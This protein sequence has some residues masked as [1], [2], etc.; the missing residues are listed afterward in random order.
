MKKFLTTSIVII[1]I[2]LTAVDVLAMSSD[3]YFISLTKISASFVPTHVNDTPRGNRIPPR[4]IECTISTEHISISSVDESEIVL[5]E[6]YDIHENCIGSFMDRTEFITFL[7]SK[8]EDIEIRIY[9]NEYVLC[10]FLSC[11][12]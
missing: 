5:F 12:L 7:F 1:T 10:G 3:Y 4:P 6:V 9:T 11:D 8:H 2:L